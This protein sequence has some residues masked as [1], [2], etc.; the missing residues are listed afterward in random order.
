M[1]LERVFDLNITCITH[2]PETK[3]IQYSF[4]RSQC[5]SLLC[6]YVL[7]Y[8]GDFI[9]KGA[10]NHEGVEVVPDVFHLNHKTN[11]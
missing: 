8:L 10:A 9:T 2:C 1:E 11:Q 7:S 3:Q 6:G 4:Q 5:K